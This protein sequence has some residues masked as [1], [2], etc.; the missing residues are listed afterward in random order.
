MG[1]IKA[2]VGSAGGVLA[3]QWKEYFYCDSIDADTLIVKGS[4]RTSGRSSN[5]KASDNIISAGS[6]VAVAD[7]QCMLIVEQGKVVEVCAEPGEFTFDSSTEPTVFAG[8]FGESLVDALRNVG[9]RFTFGG[10]P[11]KDQRVYYVNTKELLGNKYGTAGTVPFKIAD[12]DTG[13]KFTMNIKCFGEYSYH[14]CNPVLLYTAVA[15]NVTDSYLRES[16]DSQLKSELLNALQ[17]AF[18]R[19]SAQ[20]IEYDQLPAHTTELAEILNDELSSKWRDLRGIE[21]V[22][23]GIS[24][25]KA[26]EE[27]EERLKQMQLAAT[28]GGGNIA[29][30]YSVAATGES[31]RTAAGNEGGAMNAFMGMGMA[32]AFG[33]GMVQTTAGLGAQQQAAQPVQQAQPAQQQAAAAGGW[34]CSCGAANTGKFCAECGSPKPEPA[35]SWVCS[36][37]TSNTGKFCAECGKPK[38]SVECSK[39]GW[40]PADGA[41]PK[42]CLECGTPFGA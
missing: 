20:H 25:V 6:M 13:L 21:I 14:V 7:G 24:S 9:K 33:G 18:A 31:M 17:P 32:N 3:D 2:A 8:D 34:T 15:G 26:N 29:M 42:F 5:T 16:M 11:P 35:G 41:A 36:C 4:K 27:D 1:L 19:I 37:G 28:L 12:P 23:F 10:E 22:S 38:P 39:C 30:G 40:K